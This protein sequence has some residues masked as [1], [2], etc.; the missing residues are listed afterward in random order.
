MA[1]LLEITPRIV[2]YGSRLV[3]LHQ[4]TSVQLASVSPWRGFG[5]LLIGLG[6]ALL[7]AVLA[8]PRTASGSLGAGFAITGNGGP[9]VVGLL[10]LGLGLLAYFY[11]RDFL[12]IATA[13]GEK[14]RITSHDQR[15]MMDVVD[16]IRAAMS[17][18][19]GSELHYVVNVVDRQIERQGLRMGRGEGEFA[20]QGDAEPDQNDT[21]PAA[22]PVAASAEAAGEADAPDVRPPG[23]RLNV[24]VQPVATPRSAADQDAIRRCGASWSGLGG[25][26][27]ST[28][29][30]GFNPWCAFTGRYTGRHWRG[31][32]FAAGGRA[33]GGRRGRSGSVVGGGGA[34]R[35]GASGR[36]RR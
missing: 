1:A 20:A 10:L 31:D 27:P 22:A 28:R 25:Y 34:Q 14:L 13:D 5:R 8:L 19:P 2:A 7:V 12:V 32:R 21:V 36:R 23:P 16:A 24:P 4:V 18:G 9:S 11:N 35:G 30:C 29:R 15:F 3:Q 33:T 17:A 26:S 6:G